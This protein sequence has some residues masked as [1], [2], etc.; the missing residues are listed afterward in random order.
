LSDHKQ[1]KIL[2]CSRFSK[3]VSFNINLKEVKRYA[4]FQTILICIFQLY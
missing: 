2:S 1:N 4:R 3:T